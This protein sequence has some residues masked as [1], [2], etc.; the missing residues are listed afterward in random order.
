M[1]GGNKGSAK[2]WKPGLYIA[3]P[4]AESTIIYEGCKVA[5]NDSG[6]LI[7]AAHNA[8]NI[9]AFVGVSREYVDNSAGA[10]GAKVCNIVREGAY[11]MLTSGVTQANVG[12]IAY[13]NVGQTASVDETVKVGST[14]GLT[15]AIPTGKVLRYISTTKVLVDIYAAASG[16]L[17]AE[18]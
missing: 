3:L 4:V 10:N 2:R 14:A 1:A 11:E 16:A 8:T 15:A 18:E 7:M 12:D 5:V 13:A 17:D 6:Y 9:K